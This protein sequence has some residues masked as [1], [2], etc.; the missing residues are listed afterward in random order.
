MQELPMNWDIWVNH[1]MTILSM[2]DFAVAVGVHHQIKQLYLSNC[3]TVKKYSK[4]LP[5]DDRGWRPTTLAK[6]VFESGSFSSEA[7]AEY[8]N[9]HFCTIIAKTRNLQ[10]F[11]WAHHKKL[12][13]D[14]QTSSSAAQY[15]HLSV[16]K[17]AHENGCPWNQHIC[18][19]AASNGDLAILQYAHENECPWN[20]GAS[21]PGQFVL[22]LMPNACHAAAKAGHLEC[23]MYAHQNGCPWDVWT[24]SQAAGNG[25][26]ECLKYAH[27]NGCPWDG[28]TCTEAAK[29]WQLECLRYA[30][31]HGCPQ[32]EAVT[33]YLRAILF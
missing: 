26:F 3:A 27:E 10:V 28:F 20:K 5:K 14:E 6:T 31:E 18:S 29:N 17:Y 2:G 7:C 11:Q 25:H 4:E 19:W 23:L 1:I 15:G 30:H 32:S 12:P 24:C 21:P 9:R 22:D 33:Q 16:L 8:W 13:W